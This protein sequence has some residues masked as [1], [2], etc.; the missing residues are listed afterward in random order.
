MKAKSPKEHSRDALQEFVHV[1]KRHAGKLTLS[2]Y[3]D[4]YLKSIAKV[5]KNFELI[6]NKSVLINNEEWQKIVHKA[7][8]SSKDVDIINEIYLYVNKN[9]RYSVTCCSQENSYDKYKREFRKIMK[10]ITIK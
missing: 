10:S 1:A 3:A 9:D 8:V 5:Y 4:T 6:S 2:L 7:T